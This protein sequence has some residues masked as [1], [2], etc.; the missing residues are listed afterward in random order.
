[1]RSARLRQRSA[2]PNLRSQHPFPFPLS[3][4]RIKANVRL[5]LSVSANFPIN[6]DGQDR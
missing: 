5:S 2:Q 3:I 4:D 6:M 1:M